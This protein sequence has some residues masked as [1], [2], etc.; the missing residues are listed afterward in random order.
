M[1]AA[2]WTG[3]TWS[4]WAT[5][6]GRAARRSATDPRQ[7]AHEAGLDLPEPPRFVD[8]SAPDKG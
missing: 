5:A 8:F 3:C 4:P 7:K 2:R 6:D 1:C